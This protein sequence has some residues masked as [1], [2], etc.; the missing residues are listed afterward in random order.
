MTLGNIDEEDGVFVVPQEVT[1]ISF[2]VSLLY[3]LDGVAVIIGSQLSI[4]YETEDG[5]RYEPVNAA[6]A[7]GIVET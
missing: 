4:F 2:S 5:V 3:T 1:T 7:L 6:A